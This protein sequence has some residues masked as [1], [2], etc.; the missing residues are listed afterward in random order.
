MMEPKRK[1]TPPSP[2]YMTDEQFGM[3]HGIEYGDESPWLICP[4][5]E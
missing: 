4:S 2:S 3:T 5:A 1:V